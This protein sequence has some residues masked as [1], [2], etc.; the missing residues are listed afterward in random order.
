[1]TDTVTMTPEEFETWRAQVA[2]L[3]EAKRAIQEF[4]D[5]SALSYEEAERVTVET[6]AAFAKAANRP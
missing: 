1:M 4:A 6:M 2:E 5:K 3:P